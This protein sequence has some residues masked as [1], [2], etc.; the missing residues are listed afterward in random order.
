MFEK[1]K[2]K[3]AEIFHRK[4]IDP[5]EVADEIPLKL[6]EADV[7]LE[8]AE[9]LASLVRNKLKEDTTLDPNE[10]L[11][12]SILEMMPE[13][14]FDVLNVNKKPFVVLFLG[15]NGTGKTTTIG[16]FAHYLKRNGKSVVIAAADTF[17]AGAI[18][19]ISLIGREAGTEVIRHDR[20]SDPSSV[21]FDAIEH[22]RAR[23]IDYV[24]IDTAGRMNTNK[25]LLD[26]MKKIK[27]VSK[28]DLTLLVIDAV[29]GQDS[30]N[31]AR[32]F[33][34]NVGY[35]GVI[36]TKLDTDAR[37]GSILSI[38]HDLKKPVLFVCTGQ[39]LDDIMPFDRNWYVRKLIPE[40]ENETA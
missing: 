7:S 29:S 14:K 24:L 33:E 13:Y 19:Q 10:V 3:F 40:P 35:D 17:R 32:M 22:A 27:R 18:E 8:A 20:G 26:E 31:Q 2:K 9:D 4:K 16:K 28:P 30:V 39:G 23:N 6:V 21:A 37:G 38:Y 25:N 36:V 11:S 5:D 12:S 1:L 15:I 34:E